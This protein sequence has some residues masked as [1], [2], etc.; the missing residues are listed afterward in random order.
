MKPQSTAND[1]IREL[2]FQPSVTSVAAG[3]DVYL[4]TSTDFEDVNA[5]VAEIFLAMLNAMP[6]E[7]FRNLLAVLK[8]HLPDDQ[9]PNKTT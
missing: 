6:S 2:D 8:V 7:E 3:K 1:N 5:I 9:Q 4:K